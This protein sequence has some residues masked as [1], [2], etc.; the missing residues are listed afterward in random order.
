MRKATRFAP[1]HAFPDPRRY[2]LPG[3]AS[4][5][6]SALH[7]LAAHS[8]AGETGQAADGFDEAIATRLAAILDRGDG[9]TLASTL[10]AAPTLAV[11]RHLWRC[12]ARLA[13]TAAVGKRADWA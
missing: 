6:A 11:Y 2:A 12:I 5:E 9:A 13:A 7:D 10:D 8:L 4:A 3:T 1:M